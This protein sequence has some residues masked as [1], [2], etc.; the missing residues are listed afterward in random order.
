M[1]QGFDNEKLRK[2]KEELEQ[3]FGSMGK[4]SQEDQKPL[5]EEIKKQHP[6]FTP[7]SPDLKIDSE[8]YHKEQIFLS[9]Q[10]SEH[11]VSNDNDEND[12][13]FSQVKAMTA[14]LSVP[15]SSVI[16]LFEG[17]PPKLNNG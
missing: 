2:E 5:D 15:L 7:S 1:A 8:T 12:F 11:R 6:Q 13:F 10:K 14:A 9:H 16:T 3:R 4:T 17:D